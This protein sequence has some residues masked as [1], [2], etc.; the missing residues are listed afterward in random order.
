MLIVD[1]GERYTC[2]LVLLYFQFN[3][4]AYLPSKTFQRNGVIAVW[5]YLKVNDIHG[6]QQIEIFTD[7]VYHRIYDFEVKFFHFVSVKN[8]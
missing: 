5:Q 2:F 4:K 1:L 3:G 6:R 8:V 7:V